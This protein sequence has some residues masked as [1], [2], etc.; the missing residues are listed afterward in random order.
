[1]LV[2]S[3]T[4]ATP[5]HALPTRSRT[6][7]CQDCG[8]YLTVGHAEADPP[9]CPNAACIAHSKGGRPVRVPDDGS[10]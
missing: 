9:R 4:D 5:G 6:F 10:L 3:R 8:R 7:F 2:F 1:M